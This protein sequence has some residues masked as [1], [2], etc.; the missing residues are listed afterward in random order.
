MAA[1]SGTEEVAKS[2]LFSLQFHQ[3]L[4]GLVGCQGGRLVDDGNAT[5]HAASPAVEA[6]FEAVDRIPE[7]KE[8][9]YGIAIE[10][11]GVA[12]IEQVSFF[13]IGWT[14]DGGSFGACVDRFIIGRH[15]AGFGVGGVFYVALYRK[16]FFSTAAFRAGGVLYF[17]AVGGCRE[18]VAIVAAN[19]VVAHFF[20]FC[21]RW[22]VFQRVENCLYANDTLIGV[23]E[24]QVKCIWTQIL[25]PLYIKDNTKFGKSQISRPAYGPKKACVSAPFL[26]MDTN[27]LDRKRIE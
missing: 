24:R 7:I 6:S 22:N 13:I 5:P 8:L 10:V 27:F 4:A 3:Q 12:K 18:C 9:G 20:Q 2:V 16:S 1:N 23:V 11:R 15:K 19:D 21:G 17:F 26:P 25:S 14:T